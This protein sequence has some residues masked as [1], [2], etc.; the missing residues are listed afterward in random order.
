MADNL[1]QMQEI[2]EQ[3]DQ[4]ILAIA[5]GG[6]ISSYSIAGRAITKM[7]AGD[8][9]KLRDYYQTRVDSVTSGGGVTYAH[10]GD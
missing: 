4:A 6:A 9:I 3:L 10:M 7:S 5:T 1:A 8:M 2:V